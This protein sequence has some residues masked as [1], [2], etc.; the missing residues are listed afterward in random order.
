MALS[1]WPTDLYL[2]GSW[3]GASDG[4]RLTVYDPAT[5]GVVGDVAQATVGD[6]DAAITAA[7][8]A[9]DE[10][11]WGRMSVAERLEMLRAF[12]TGLEAREATLIDIVV[13]EAGVTVQLARTAQVKAPL[14]H[15]R[16]MVDRVLPTFSFVRPQ[17]P[18]FGVGIGQGVVRREPAGVV[19]AITAFNWPVFLNVSKIAP[20]LAAGC[21]IVLRPSPLTP[22]SALLLGEVADEAGLPPGVL[23]IVT[24][25]IE[26]AALLTNHPAVDVVSFTGSDA[27]G[28]K[29]MAQAAAGVKKTILE[30][31]GKSANIVLED[32]DLARAAPYAVTNFTRHAG[33]GCACFT[34]VLVHESRHDEL[35]ERMLAILGGLRVGD[36]TD[37]ATD[38]GPLISAAQRDRVERYV[39]IGREEGATIAFGGGRPAGLDNGFFVEP[40]LFTDVKNSMCIAREEIFGPVGVVI[41]FASDDEAASIANDS[42]FGLSAA[43]WSKD[44]VRAYSLATRLR[45]GTVTLNGGGGGVNAHGPFGGYKIS[46]VGREFG[47]AGLDEYL[48]TK[49]V[50][51]AVASG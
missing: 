2:D 10:G 45:V 48:E 7:R 46:G 24:G 51:W 21:T 18:T 20:A 33:Q 4:G 41:P 23:N 38:V 19:A 44:A 39:A 31:G 30:L 47:E 3:R 32:A 22:Y 43:V 9:F 29:V 34:R 8:R 25:G 6:V 27:V 26:A 17:P 1:T 50:N 14:M 37:P 49:T 36:P 13:A 12:A 16:D 40:T 35:V 5:G 15:F 42:T 11:P 28:R